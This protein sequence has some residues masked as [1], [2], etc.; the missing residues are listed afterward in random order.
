MSNQTIDDLCIEVGK[1]IEY[2]GFKEIEGRIWCHILLA[3]TPLCA[4]D[5]MTKTG[6]SKG[7]ISISLKRLLEYD[8]ICYEY[9]LGRRTEFFSINSNISDVIKSVLINRE[10]KILSGVMTAIIKV[11]KCNPGDI[12]DLNRKRLQY[13]KRIVKN[14]NRYLKLIIMGGE[15]FSQFLFERAPDL[16]VN[17]I[18]RQES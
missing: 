9:T 8:V 16:S 3:K 6:V 17:P 4:S 13:L 12:P 14:A 7:L 15:A 2:W 10:K 5:L 1:F 11:E 18:K